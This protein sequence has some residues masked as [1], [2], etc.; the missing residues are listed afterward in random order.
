VKNSLKKC[1][2][3]FKGGTSL[4]P[5]Q[6]TRRANKPDKPDMKNQIITAKIVALLAAGFTIEAA[7]EQVFGA[8]SFEKIA[9]QIY[10][11]LRAA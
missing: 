3:A 1:L 8:G 2:R 10:D 5:T 6:G 7:I 9:G 4:S 11:M